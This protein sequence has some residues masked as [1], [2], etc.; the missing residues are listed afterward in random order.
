VKIF[1]A[2][3]VVHSYCSM[4]RGSSRCLSGLRPLLV[5]VLRIATICLLHIFPS[6]CCGIGGPFAKLCLRMVPDPNQRLLDLLLV[7][8]VQGL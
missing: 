6:F 7:F 2:L 1:V 4:V 3:S 8:A 5:K